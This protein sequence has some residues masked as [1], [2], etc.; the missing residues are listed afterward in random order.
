MKKLIIG[1]LC[2]SALVLAACSQ[3]ETAQTPTA[4]AVQKALGSGIELQN[5]DSSIRPQ[6]DFYGYV[7]GTW[8]KTAEIPS[9]R[10]T[11][12][13][14]Y[15]LREKAQADVKAIIEELAATEG[16]KAGSDEQKVA[17]LYRSMMDTDTI[18]QLGITPLKGEFDTIAALKS[19]DDLA[20]YFARSQTIGG[21]TP[22]AFYVSVDAKD[23]S[24]YATH[25]WQYGLSLPDRDYYFNDAERFQKIRDGYVAHI[26]KMFEL[27][28]LPNPK[29]SAQTVMAIE[30]D[31]A[32]HHWTRVE[33]RDS[34]KRYNKYAV[35]DLAKLTDGFNWSRYLETM[36]VAD[37]ADIIINQPSYI[38]GFGEVFNDHSLE[39]WKTYATWHTL[40]A[41]AG[42]LSAD[43][44]NENFDFFA[45]QLNGQAEQK[46]R[47][48]RGV[49]KVNGDLG[50]VV[51][52]VYVKRHFTPEAKARMSELVENLRRAYGESIDDLEWMSPETKVKAKE[53]LAAFTPKIGYPDRWQD[54]STLE[55]K[56]DDLV[57]N[58][59][60]AAQ[61]QHQ[62]EIAKLGGPIQKWEWHMTPQTVNAYYNPTMNE[63]V[64][65][66]AILQ[67]PFFNM[68]AEDAVNYG[69]IGAV[70]GHEM[71]H[72]FDDQGS[73]Y[74]GDGNLKNWW[75][76]DDLKAFQERGSKLVKQYAAY[77]VFEDLNVNGKLTLGENIGDL[78]GATIAYRA[79][80]MALDGKD[81][82]VIDG[83]SGDERFFIGF[84]QIWRAKYKEQALR[85]RVA[86][87]PHSPSQFRANGPLANMPEFYETYNVQ[88]TDAM[89]IAPEDR[90]KI[91]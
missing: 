75:T 14:F 7:N 52:K 42:Q 58:S 6:D 89:Y 1:G 20:A 81:A 76:E 61:W 56:A 64:F 28:G 87:D 67:P 57:G 9:D 86:T 90:V 26:E 91:W 49:D 82:P 33:S 46:A 48:K 70:I 27:A 47:W 71:G 66:A 35:A 68:E 38:E 45:R 59:M 22:L 63:I 72:G 37:Q 31:L 11:T 3:T 85:N 53:K 16:L 39:E 30:T 2:A 23:S 41:F 40:T 43:L 19:K 12:G 51:G 32:K 69:G 54:Y 10:T 18:E 17:D 84:T 60:R 74:D 44:D 21:G 13:A 80:Q 78:S 55:V 25:I 62:Q 34:E 36:G 77:Q 79:Y 8:L 29:A 4:E 15:D 24:R 73:R 50:E 5:F 65:P 88:P 83:L